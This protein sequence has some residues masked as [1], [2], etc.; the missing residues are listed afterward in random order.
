MKQLKDQAYQS[1]DKPQEQHACYVAL[2]EAHIAVQDHFL[3]TL[4]QE[5]DQII[6]ELTKEQS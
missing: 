3:K 1:S 5:L 4:Q 6:I 2:L